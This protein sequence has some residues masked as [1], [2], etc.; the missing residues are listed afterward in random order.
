[1]GGGSVGEGKVETAEGLPIGIG[2]KRRGGGVGA[3]E[4]VD[5]EPGVA[6][7]AEAEVVV[8]GGVVAVVD[9]GKFADGAEGV[10]RCG[11][12]SG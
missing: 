12:V 9:A 2:E 4:A 8:V 7:L 1:M 10:L 5:V 11:K 6:R 3:G